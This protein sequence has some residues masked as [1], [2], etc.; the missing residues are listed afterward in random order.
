[1]DSDLFN[2]KPVDLLEVLQKGLLLYKRRFEFFLSISLIYAIFDQLAGIGITRLKLPFEETLFLRA[3]VDV[4][5]VSWAAI[6]I[7]F[8]ASRLARGKTFLTAK[9]LAVARERYGAYLSVDVTRMMILEL[10]VLFFI[11]PGLY[12][13]TLFLF[14]GILVVAQ[15]ADFRQAFDLSA[16]LVRPFFWKVFTFIMILIG[17]SLVPGVLHQALSFHPPVAGG[18]QKVSAVILMPYLMITQVI[19]FYEI[20]SRVERN[21]Q[22]IEDQIKA[23]D[24][25]E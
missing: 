20:R 19:L 3:F 18:I 14:T 11:V 21:V 12:F 17:M 9:A 2:D 8:G 23:L 10:G 6:P 16:R 13:M 5:I 7:F 25:D 4:I 22:T 24:Q 1:M 15:K